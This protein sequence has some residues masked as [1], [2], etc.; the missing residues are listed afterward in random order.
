MAKKATD[1]YDYTQDA[2]VLDSRISQL[3][4]RATTLEQD[5][6]T[7]AVGVI[8]YTIGSGRTELLNKLDGAISDAFWRSGLRKYFDKY[9]PCSFNKA[10]RV[11]GVI[12][13]PA[14]WVHDKDKAKAIK[15]K[16]QAEYVAHMLAS[17]YW[18]DSKQNSDD[19]AG[20]SIVT[21]IGRLIKQHD[22]VAKDETKAKHED[23]DMRGIEQLKQLYASLTKGNA[24]A[25][26]APAATAEAVVVH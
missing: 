21:M 15:A 11:K 5:L 26:A 20:L 25:P 6:H 24:P 10:E 23:N 9:S 1:V 2:D 17:P 13:K 18:V 3:A 16:D 12:T 19:F 8:M 14:A 7:T 4:A 22:R